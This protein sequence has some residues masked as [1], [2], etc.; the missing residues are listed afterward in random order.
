VKLVTRKSIFDRSNNWL[1]HISGSRRYQNQSTYSSCI[2][3]IYIYAWK[4]K[5]NIN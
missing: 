2:L 5:E 3:Y 4:K 1:S